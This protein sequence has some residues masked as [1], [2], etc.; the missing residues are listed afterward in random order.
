MQKIFSP[1]NKI[2]GCPKK[3]HEVKHRTSPNGFG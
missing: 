2:W 3:E 1:E